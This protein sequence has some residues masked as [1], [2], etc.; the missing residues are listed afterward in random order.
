MTKIVLYVVPPVLGLG[1]INGLLV[2]RR[3]Q[4]I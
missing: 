4:K 1:F 2:H 3:I